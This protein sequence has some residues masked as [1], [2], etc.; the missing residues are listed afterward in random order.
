[1][2]QQPHDP[3]EHGPQQPL[4]GDGERLHEVSVEFGRLDL[5][6]PEGTTWAEWVVARGTVEADREER[7]IDHRTAYYIARFLSTDATP[8]LRT[9]ARTGEIDYEGMRQEITGLYGDQTAQVQ[10]WTA[11]L[12]HYLASH[13]N[14]G[15]VDGWRQAIA[16]QDHSDAE[17][18]RRER[19][20]DR[21]DELFRKVPPVQR[22]PNAG[23]PGWHAYV[24]HE[25]RSGGWIVSEGVPGGRQ[26]WETDS[27]KELEQR[28]VA[29][30]EAQRQWIVDTFGGG[31]G[32][33]PEAVDGQAGPPEEPHRSEP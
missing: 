12:A 10:S 31:D 3:D 2:E 17:W 23:Q 33:E 11:W 22:V 19:V 13:V 8:A 26:V 18:L 29:L 6:P 27:D 28:Y 15:P 21:I 4:P 24:R 25:D 9:L 7:T 5:I 1:M 32:T 20:F 30:V 16:E 14:R